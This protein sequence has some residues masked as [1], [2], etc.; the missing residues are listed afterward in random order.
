MKPQ[1]VILEATYHT[2]ERIFPFVKDESISVQVEARRVEIRIVWDEVC[3]VMLIAREAA[4]A[5]PESSKEERFAELRGQA[6]RLAE[7]LIGRGE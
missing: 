6:K 7:S 4:D 1:P 3:D 2:E 5:H